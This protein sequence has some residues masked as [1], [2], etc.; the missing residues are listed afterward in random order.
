[1]SLMHQHGRFV[2]GAS[3]GQVRTADVA[4]ATPAM[5]TCLA[6]GGTFSDFW[7]T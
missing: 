5:A 4:S 7:A 3:K 1:M 2:W 6:L